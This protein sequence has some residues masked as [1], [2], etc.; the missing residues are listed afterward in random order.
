MT[1]AERDLQQRI[2]RLMRNRQKRGHETRAALWGAL[3]DLAPSILF[4]VVTGGFLALYII[5]V[6]SGR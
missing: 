6:G 2:A 4:G 1:P 3:W 5:L